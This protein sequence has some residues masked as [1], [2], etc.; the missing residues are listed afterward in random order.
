[1]E[2]LP[3]PDVILTHESDL[4]ELRS[5][6]RRY[7]AAL[8]VAAPVEQWEQ[9]RRE[10]SVAETQFEQAERELQQRL[11]ELTSPQQVAGELEVLNTRR[12]VA[13]TLHWDHVAL[14]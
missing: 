8:Q 10:E 4:E 13:A 7:R 2:V 6:A 5:M 1:M 3:R 9:A 12:R 14:P 11:Q